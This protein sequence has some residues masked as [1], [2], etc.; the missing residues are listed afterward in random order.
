MTETC[1]DLEI[2]TPLVLHGADGSTPE[3]RPPSL[4]GMMRYWWRAAR[5]QEI[6]RLLKEEARL[7]GSSNSKTGGKSR[8]SLRFINSQLNIDKVALLPHRGDRSAQAQAFKPGQKFTVV[9]SSVTE[10]NLYQDI[11]EISLLLGGLGKRSRRGFGSLHYSRWNF[12]DKGELQNY[13]L[14]KLN[15]LADDSFETEGSVIKRRSLSGANYPFIKEISFGHPAARA[16]DLLANIGRASH[17]H[18][19]N[20]LGCF[21]P[22]MA[23][24]VCVSVVKL[25]AGFMLVI[26]MLNSKFPRDFKNY[27]L[28]K[29]DEFKKSLYG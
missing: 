17:M 22:R 23:S 5:A 14:Q 2:I 21:K 28:T 6:S 4:K 13:L 8:F 24:P 12:K 25:K 1:L 20:A 18:K 16:D 15:R 26:T 3:M 10:V 27:N 29:Q 19:N 9:L 7:F 11:L